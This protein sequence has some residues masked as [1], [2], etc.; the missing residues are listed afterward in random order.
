MS[1]FQDLGGV[2][3]TITLRQKPKGIVCMLSLSCHS[4]R[5]ARNSWIGICLRVIVN[6]KPLDVFKWLKV[7]YIN[8]YFFSF[9]MWCFGVCWDGRYSGLE[10]GDPSPRL[11]IQVFCVFFVVIFIRTEQRLSYHKSRKTKI[12]SKILI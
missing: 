4:T 2:S 10:E 8:C 11:K 7:I 9:S 12:S 5:H 3:F 1:S 6:E